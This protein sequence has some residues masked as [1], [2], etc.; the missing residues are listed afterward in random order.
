[1]GTHRRRI[2]GGRSRG[3][4]GFWLRFAPINFNAIGILIAFVALLNIANS[5]G[6]KSSGIEGRA[7]SIAASAVLHVGLEIGASVVASG[8]INAIVGSLVLS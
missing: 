5:I 4:V 7:H 2:G 3:G 8:A 6:A 1:M